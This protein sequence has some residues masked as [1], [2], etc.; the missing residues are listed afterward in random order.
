MAAQRSRLEPFLTLISGWPRRL[1]ALLCLMLAA[2]AATRTSGRPAVETIPVSVAART[3]QAGSLLGAGD[4]RVAAWPRSLAP[5]GRIAVASAVLGRRVGAP[6]ARGEPITTQRLLDTAIVAALKPHQVAM[7]VRLSDD[8]Q[9]A[10]LRAG[11]LIDLDPT[12]LSNRTVVDGQP[13]GSAP[14]AGHPS[15]E[16]VRILAVL[17]SPDE[18]AQSLPSLVVAADTSTVSR[19]AAMAGTPMIATLKPPR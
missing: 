9:L 12:D 11:A 1:A 17:P 7:T 3:L 8:G 6:M 15:A 5:A 19:L 13:V 4:V 10:V 14:A 2:L 18:S 16:N